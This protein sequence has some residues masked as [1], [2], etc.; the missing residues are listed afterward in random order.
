MANLQFL[1]QQ[2]IWRGKNTDPGG[3]LKHNRDMIFTFTIVKDTNEKGQ[4]F[5][6]YNVRIWYVFIKMKLIPILN[7]KNYSK[8]IINLN[9]NKLFIKNI[10]YYAKKDTIN[11]MPKVDSIKQ[12]I[13]N[14][15]IQY[16][17]ILSVFVCSA[18]LVVPWQPGKYT[19]N[20]TFVLDM[21][22]AFLSSYCW[23]WNNVV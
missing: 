21:K 4:F 20:T 17:Y 16:I 13:T 11:K 23:S 19:S 3:A 5:Q 1:R 10:L 18:L 6:H 22:T 9:A 12:T 8:R 15:N 7:I 14:P 2:K